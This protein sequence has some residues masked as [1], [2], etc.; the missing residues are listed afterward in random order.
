MHNNP[1]FKKIW[2]LQN[3][4]STTQ[5]STGSMVGDGRLELVFVSGN[6]YKTKFGD[7]KQTWGEGIYLGGHIDQPFD[8]EILPETKIQFVKLEPWAAAMISGFDFKQSLNQT[9]PLDQV[10]KALNHSLA[11]QS[12]S[13]FTQDTFKLL[14]KSLESTSLKR[15]KFDLLKFAAHYLENNFLNFKEN[16]NNLLKELNVSARTLETSF[17]R[18]IGLT[19]QKF[20]NTIRFRKISEQIYHCEDNQSLTELAYNFGYFDQAH[21]IK[22]CQQFIGFSPS[23]LS[24]EHCFIT[25]SNEN[26]RYYT[27]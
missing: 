17:G 10:N 15:K 24:Q 22:H 20:A 26:F 13:H 25:N 6:G 16:K 2:I 23:K 19:P 18:S 21:F 5:K 12:G 1:L 8:M 7:E 4:D 27:I 11:S 14:S 3:Q 9:I